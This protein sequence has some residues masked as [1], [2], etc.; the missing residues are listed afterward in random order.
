[1]LCLFHMGK[2]CLDTMVD[3]SDGWQ[4]ASFSWSHQ[5]LAEWFS[6]KY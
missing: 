2:L 3:I 5:V 4:M 6:V 1:M